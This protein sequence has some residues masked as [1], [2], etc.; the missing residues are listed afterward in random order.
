MIIIDNPISLEEVQKNHSH[1]YETL[2]KGVVDIEKE[3]IGLDAEM[4]ADIEEEMLNQGS[5][6]Y[7]LWGF[8]ITFEKPYNIQYASLINIRPGQG[9]KK[10]E[11][12]SRETKEKVNILTHKL[13]IQ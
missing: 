9:N 2:V 6:Q 13:I 3:I 8:N 5:D 7:N 4:H 11:I 12:E 1:F 10:M